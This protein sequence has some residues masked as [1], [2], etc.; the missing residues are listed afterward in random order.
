MNPID[1]YNKRLNWLENITVILMCVFVFSLPFSES[2]ISLTAGL[3]IL[4]QLIALFFRKSEIKKLFSDKSLWLISSIVVVYLIGLIFTSDMNMGRYE[5]R[6]IIFWPVLTFGIALAPKLTEKKFWLVFHVFI[7]SV[8]ASTFFSFGKMLVSSS[9][10]VEN[11]RDVNYVSHIPFSFQITLCIVILIYSFIL[12]IPFLS[13]LNRFVRIALIIWLLIFLVMLKSMVGLIAFYI[14]AF[15]LF[16]YLFKNEHLKNVRILLIALAA[17]VFVVPVVY[18]GSVV[19][20]F[21]SIKDKEKDKIGAVTALGNKYQFE[22]YHAMKENGHYVGWFICDKELKKTWNDRSSVKYDEKDEFGYSIAETLKRY[23]TSKG[24]HKDAEGVTQLSERDIL[25]IQEGMANYIYDTRVYAIYPRIY[26]TIWELDQYFHTGNPNDRSLA[27]RIEYAKASINIIKHNFWFGVGT[28]NYEIE[29]SKAFKRI[30]SKLKVNNYGSAH[31]Q[32][33]SYFLKFG[34]VG[35]IYIFW[36]VFSVIYFKK[37]YRNQLF[38]LFFIQIMVAN[39]GDS[40]WE[41]HVG[42]AYFVFFFV[43]FLW[44]SPKNLTPKTSKN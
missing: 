17:V 28:G 10:T 3:L 8:T 30:N 33:L 11:F 40:N 4:I 12:T 37:Q 19:F 13:R 43:M 41:T 24:L 1:A 15:A 18:V 5:L 16:L 29:F 7:F 31:D 26:E 36:V 44:N 6:K 14:M 32:Y 9:Y 2:L 34:F 23:L 20:K 25:N 27:Q 22:E 39:L 21:Y 35:F 38:M 42:L